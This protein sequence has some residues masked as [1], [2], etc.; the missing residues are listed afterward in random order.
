M[1]GETKLK[2]WRPTECGTRIGDVVRTET[3]LLL[4][5]VKCRRCSK[6]SGVDIFHYV[7]LDKSEMPFSGAHSPRE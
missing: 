5:K 1:I 4:L 2:E 3:G 7:T 6:D